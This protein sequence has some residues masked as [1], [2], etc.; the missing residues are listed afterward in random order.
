MKASSNSSRAR[1]SLIA[2]VEG[3]A[4]PA[5][6]FRSLRDHGIGLTRPELAVVMA[7]AKIDL[8]NPPDR[9]EGGR[10]IRPSRFCSKDYFPDG[11]S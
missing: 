1:A 2:S 7:Y 6:G 11:G 5:D 10:M 9:I 4:P 3:P 8:F